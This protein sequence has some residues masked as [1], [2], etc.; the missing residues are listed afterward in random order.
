M[1]A[2]DDTPGDAGGA[3]LTSSEAADML[4]VSVMTLRRY[5]EAGDLRASR[6]GPK[7]LIRIRPTDLTAYVEANQTPTPATPPA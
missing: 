6:I 2:T 4:G 5:V 1:T 7:K 3:M